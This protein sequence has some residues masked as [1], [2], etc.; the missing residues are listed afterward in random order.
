MIGLDLTTFVIDGEVVQH[1]REANIGWKG[2]ERSEMLYEAGDEF[3]PNLPSV[4]LT[5]THR[6]L[7]GVGVL[8]YPEGSVLSEEIRE[9]GEFV[10]TPCRVVADE[11]IAQIHYGS[12][13]KLPSYVNEHGH[14]LW[15]FRIEGGN[16]TQVT[17]ERIDE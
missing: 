1:K 4:E 9:T 17:V 13:I 10:T 12:I 5:Y 15:D 16:P 6:Q 3:V 8:R 14:Y 2:I 11:I 7:N